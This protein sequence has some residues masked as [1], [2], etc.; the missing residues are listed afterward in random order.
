VRAIGEADD[1]VGIDASSDTDDFTSLAVEG[2]M[3]M[4]DGHIFQR[5]LE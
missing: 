4:G 2:M 1:Q 5:G 3:R